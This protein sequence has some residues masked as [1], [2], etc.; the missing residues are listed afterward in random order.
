MYGHIARRKTMTLANSRRY[1]S[2]VAQYIHPINIHKM[3]AR[4]GFR[5]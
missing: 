4:G 3:P 1:F 2:R 5:L